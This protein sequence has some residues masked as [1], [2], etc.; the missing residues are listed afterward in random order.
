[1]AAPRLFLSMFVL[2]L[3]V[4]TLSEALRGSGPKRCC[5]SFKENAVP[6]ERVVS[7]MKTSQRCPKSAIL[8]KTGGGRYICAKPSA[9]WV[10]NL[11]SY[12]D[13][14]AVPGEASNL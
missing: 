4:I 1:M 13:N 12:L 9:T 11:I 3:A 2:M 6:K 14:K 7:Y 8:F 10:K 5:F